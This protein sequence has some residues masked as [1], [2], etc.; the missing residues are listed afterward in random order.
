MNG[1]TYH[2][3]ISRLFILVGVVAVISLFDYI[4]NTA[5]LHLSLAK[6]APTTFFIYVSHEVYI[7]NLLKGGW[8]KVFYTE[9]GWGK[10]MGY[11]IVPCLCII[12]CM[13]LYNLIKIISPQLLNLLTGGRM[14]VFKYKAE[15]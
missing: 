15:K 4:N 2:E 7:I 9:S 6:L 5:R 10:L 1:T 11:F 8:T 14:T 13:G 3:Y 12:V